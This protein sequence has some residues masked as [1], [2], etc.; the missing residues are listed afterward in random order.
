MNAHS[1]ALETYIASAPPA[2]VR[3][4]AARGY[5]EEQI[6]AELARRAREARQAMF[7]RILA[8]PPPQPTLAI[9]GPSPGIE[10]EV[11]DDSMPRIRQSREERIASA[12]WLSPEVKEK[13]RPKI[14]RVLMETAEEFGIDVA[15]LVSGSRL[16]A[17]V[18]PRHVAVYLCR[19]LCSVGGRNCVT[20]CASYP[21]LGRIFSGRDHTTMISSYRACKRRMEAYPSFAIRVKRLR[22]R[23]EGQ[24]EP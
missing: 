10:G 4:W 11:P 1:P 22:E 16:G 6:A 13:Q 19:E 21:A 14:K 7:A 2:V 17:I 12:R 20:N 8:L 23:I 24:G 5:T 15:T 18:G 3:A 9:A